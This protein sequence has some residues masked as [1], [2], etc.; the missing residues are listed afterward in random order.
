[1]LSSLVFFAFFSS[2]SRA[3]FFGFGFTVLIFLSSALLFG[4][5]AVFGLYIVIN[6]YS[7]VLSIVLFSFI[8]AVFFLF[9]LNF[10]IRLALSYASAYLNK[11]SSFSGNSKKYDLVNDIYDLIDKERDSNG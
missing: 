11:L 8:F 7:S 2:N 9:G 4:G 6:N 10:G 5:V 3:M 1:M